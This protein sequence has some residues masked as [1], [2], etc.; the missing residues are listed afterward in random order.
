[1]TNEA[2]VDIVEETVEFVAVRE[3]VAVEIKQLLENIGSSYIKVGALLNEAREDFNKQSEFLSWALTEFGIKKAQCYNLMSIAKTFGNDDRFNGVAMRVMLAL[4]EHAG[5]E[6]IMTAAAALAAEGE[7]T[8]STLNDLIEPA[9]PV[10]VQ[11]TAQP[12][13]PAPA[14]R[15]QLQDPTEGVPDEIEMPWDT[16]DSAPSAQSSAVRETAPADT[17]ADQMTADS[18]RVAGLLGLI[19]TLRD[20]NRQLAEEV[21]ALR[22][23]RTV[24]KEAAP[25]LPQFKSKCMYARLGLSAEEATKKTA[26]NKAKRELVKLGY[27]AGHEA[28]PLIEEAVNALTVE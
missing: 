3:S 9:R 1:M 19:E 10:V 8:T 6:A 16:Q 24:K 21:A 18:E 25:M 27:G 23:E 2:V 28:W 15:E 7:L 12:A 11:M 20:T 14:P 17:K 4:V 5:N 13:P 22:S 26:V